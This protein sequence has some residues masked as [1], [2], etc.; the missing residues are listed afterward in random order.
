VGSLGYGRVL[1]SPAMAYCDLQAQLLA[2][3]QEH[4]PDTA[5]QQV[6]CNTIGK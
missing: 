2:Y 3:A 4:A 6:T 1:E 5:A